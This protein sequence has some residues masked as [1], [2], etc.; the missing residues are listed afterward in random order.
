MKSKN[1]LD[2]KIITL[3]IL[4][5]ILLGCQAEPEL[6]NS[7]DCEGETVKVADKYIGIVYFN[8]FYDYGIS[9]DYVGGIIRVKPCNDIDSAYLFEGSQLIVSGNIKTPCYFGSQP[10]TTS[11]PSGYSP[12]DDT[13]IAPYIETQENQ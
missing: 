7:C 10:S 2:M 5:I 9:L 1:P 4:A 11:R 13:F 3:S 6:E 8:D 12:N